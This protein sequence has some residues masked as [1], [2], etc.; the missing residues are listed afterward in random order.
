MKIP[1][2]LLWVFSQPS[3]SVPQI[4][5]RRVGV[6]AG[7]SVKAI[8]QQINQTRYHRH[9][10]LSSINAGRTFGVGDFLHARVNAFET[11]S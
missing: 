2:Q 3:S 10:V 8:D 5:V 7:L 11:T 4:T 6:S 9:P 1:A